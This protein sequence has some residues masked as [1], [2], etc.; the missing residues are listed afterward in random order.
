MPAPLTRDEAARRREAVVACHNEGLPLA[1]G[2]RRLGIKPNAFREWIGQEGGVEMVL[3]AAPLVALG[4]NV[5][6]PERRPEDAWAAGTDTFDRT[7]SKAVAKRGRALKRPKGPVTIFHS[8]DEHVD[9]N[10]TPLRLIEHD[11]QAAKDL[12]A[13][14]CHGGDL[15]N[16]WP[17]AGK[18]AKQWAEQDCPLPDALLRAQHFLTIFDPDVATMGNHEEMNPYLAQLLEGWMPKKTITDYWTVRF[19]VETPGGRRVRAALSHKL[20]KGSSWFHKLQGH[21]R[22]MLESEEV[23]L[24]MDGHVHSDGV[25]EHTLPERMHCALAVASA[26]YK[27]LDKYAARISRG[28]KLPKLRGRAHWIVFDTQAEYDETFGVAFKSPRQAEAYLNGLQN[29]RAA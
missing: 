17:M 6:V 16:N 11:I 19:D 9:D 1:E 13:I 12:D 3:A 20:Q 25:L 29:L 27:V 5:A 4:Y 22:E 21:I 14:M 10:A 24:L 7:L 2:A 23:D 18:L 26:G 15:L 8:T 28:G